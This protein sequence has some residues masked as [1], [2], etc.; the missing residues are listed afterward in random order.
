M[1]PTT[2]LVLE[3]KL[4]VTASLHYAFRFPSSLESILMIWMGYSPCVITQVF[5]FKVPERLITL[6]FSDWDC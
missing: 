5:I 4:I 3:L 2:V 6:P 1:D